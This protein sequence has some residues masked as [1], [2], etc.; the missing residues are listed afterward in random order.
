MHVVAGHRF[1][2]ENLAAADAFQRGE[3]SAR[4]GLV[5]PHVDHRCQRALLEIAGTAAVGFRQSGHPT[6]SGEAQVVVDV[7]LGERPADV[8][9]GGQG[10]P[11][12]R[13][14]HGGDEPLG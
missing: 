1:T 2:G 7:P 8:G 5:D 3:L 10:G 4:V 9:N 11:W 6:L 14:V 13:H 12:S